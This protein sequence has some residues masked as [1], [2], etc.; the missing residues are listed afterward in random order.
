MNKEQTFK[1]KKCNKETYIGQRYYVLG[2]SYCE[3]CYVKHQKKQLRTELR[4]I[5]G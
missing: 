5:G 4:E 3:K 2:Q 1:C